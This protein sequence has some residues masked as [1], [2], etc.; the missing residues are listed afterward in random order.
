MIPVN[1][2]ESEHT[3]NPLARLLQARHCGPKDPAAT[4]GFNAQTQSIHDEGTALLRKLQAA[5]VLAVGRIVL[6]TSIQGIY[7]CQILCRVSI[8]IARAPYTISRNFST[9]L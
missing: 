6:D 2:P 7:P 3:N 4:R 8:K 1:E 5:D 9:Q